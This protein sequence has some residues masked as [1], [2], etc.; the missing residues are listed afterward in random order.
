MGREVAFPRTRH[1]AL[2]VTGQIEEAKSAGSEAILVPIQVA[3]EQPGPVP[4]I[5]LPPPA[6][7]GGPGVPE[8]GALPPAPAPPG[9]ELPW[10]VDVDLSQPAGEPDRC[11]SAD[12]RPV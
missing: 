5:P 11:M 2:S 12:G 10:V 8:K 9:H 4:G 3:A 6:E 7:P 1:L